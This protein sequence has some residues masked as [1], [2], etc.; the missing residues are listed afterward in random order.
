[1]TKI[2]IIGGTGVYAPKLLEDVHPVTQ[3]TPYGDVEV[4]IGSYQ[5]VEAAFI[6]RHGAGHSLPP[7]LINYRANIMA[8]H[9][10]GIEQIIATAAVGSIFHEFKPGQFVLADQFIDFTKTRKA[11]FYEG[12]ASGV[13]H[14]DMT[15]PYCP[16]LREALVKSGAELNLI[17]HNGGT[18]VCSEGPRFETAAEIQ[19]IKIL[20]GH[21]VGMTSVPEVV[22]ARELGMCYAS[23]CLVTNFAAGITTG[24]LT[25]SEVVE[26]MK[27][28]LHNIHSLIVST[29]KYVERERDCDCVRSLPDTGVSQ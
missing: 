2:A 9:M 5:G 23:V 26:V 7:H 18:Y 8:L 22:L 25:H 29:L 27:K 4:T 20:G 12:G 19:A 3:K 11:T 15:V 13:V 16:D 1:M 14:C 24:I 17:I 10:L 6:A 28:S 21:L